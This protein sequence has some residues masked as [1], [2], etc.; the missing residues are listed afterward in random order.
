MTLLL[1]DEEVREA[2]DMPALVRAIEA[3]IKLETEGGRMLMPA[4]QNLNVEEGFLRVMPVVMPSTGILGLKMF[5]G[6]ATLGVRYVVMVCSLTSGDV[7]TI[8]DG[9]YLT[10][11]RTGAT[12]GV[13]T[14]KMARPGP[15]RI[16]VIGS[17]LEAETNLQAVLAVREPTEIKV[18]SRTPEK[19]NAFVERMAPEVGVPITATDTAQAA[20]RG[21]DIVIV[22]TSH[23]GAFA[24]EGAWAERGQHIVSIGSTTPQG[25]ECDH[26]TF[27]GADVVVFDTD[28]HQIV[29]ESGDIVAVAEE[30]PD[31]SDAIPLAD[32]VTGRRVARTSDD[33][34]T[35]FKSVGAAWQ[36]M[37]G[38]QS[39]YETATKRGLGT[40]VADVAMPRFF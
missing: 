3:S 39:V 10:A 5:Y 9:A 33:Q 18:F 38:A 16:G 7:L 1:Q 21:A 29:E 19:R 14:D 8:V 25:R 28:F 35:V 12:S 13:A 40:K 24:Y 17:G 23:S 22:A 15:A 27:L 2:T 37:V 4:R 36:D 30:R 20:V 32:V 26:H 6:G 31:W 11:A 34:I